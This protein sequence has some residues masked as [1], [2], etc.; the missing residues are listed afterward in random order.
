LQTDKF[1]LSQKANQRGP[2]G[3]SLKIRQYSP[4]FAAVMQKTS[5]LF[6][7]VRQPA[8][9]DSQVGRGNF[10][11]SG[12]RRNINRAA[13]TASPAGTLAKNRATQNSR[14]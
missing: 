13:F 11:E 10:G 9:A 3:G 5:A 6:L 4:A 7:Q 2:R 14:V 1:F 12:C 8:P